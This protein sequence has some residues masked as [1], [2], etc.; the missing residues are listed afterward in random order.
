MQS[1]LNINQP[2]INHPFLS[3]VQF[4]SI[5]LAP[6]FPQAVVSISRPPWRCLLQQTLTLRSD[7]LEILLKTKGITIEDIIW[8][9]SLFN[10]N[11][12]M[13]GAGAGLQMWHQF[14]SSWIEALQPNM[15]AKK[16]VNLPRGRG[17]AKPLPNFWFTLSSFIVF[18]EISIVTFLRSDNMRLP[19]CW[20][21][22]NHLGE[23]V[24][25][26]QTQ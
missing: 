15:F 9:K 8:T 25:E 12:V 13:G 3:T 16:A 19:A 24:S 1:S 10:T 7:V 11:Y 2:I 26:L 4:G 22:Y 20:S 6:G 18:S 17:G 5:P 21:H 14:F 23:D